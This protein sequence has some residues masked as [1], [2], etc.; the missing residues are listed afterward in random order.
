MTEIVQKTI[1]IDD[2]ST[3]WGINNVH[4]ELFRAHFHSL[5][6]TSR[7]NELKIKGKDSDVERC[8]ESLNKLIK[9]LHNKGS[10]TKHDLLDL[11]EEKHT[12]KDFQFK[13][14]IVGYTHLGKPIV[15]QSRNQQL[16]IESVLSKDLT[17][18]IGPAGSG[19]TYLS[20]AMAI[21]LLKANQVRKIILCRPAVEAGESLGFLPGDM[22]EKIDPF[23]QPLYDALQEMLSAKKLN[24]M[25]QDGI[26]QISP[27]AYMRGRTLKDACVIL[28][29]AQNATHSQLKMF[30]TRMGPTSKYIVTG[31]ITQIDLPRNLKSGLRATID[32]LKPIPEIGIMN[33]ALVD[34]VRHPLV[35]KIVDALE[36]PESNI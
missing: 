4:L 26:I 34:I 8:A 28:D 14:N 12:E 3:L 17:F 31:D 32:A 36:D 24:D 5:R 1:E 9:L 6:L 22:K 25:M 35:K 11:L 27:L 30:L 23:L 15:P 20:I 21:Q 18:A 33:L 2:P 13:K 29:E 16:L 10:I 7:G 19:K